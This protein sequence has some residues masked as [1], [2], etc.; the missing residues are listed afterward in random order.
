MTFSAGARYAAVICGLCAAALFLSG[1]ASLG[2]KGSRVVSADGAAS[3][4]KVA[5]IVTESQDTITNDVLPWLQYG[6]AGTA[7]TM[8]CVAVVLIVW[9]NRNSY[10]FQKPKYEA[11]KAEKIRNGNGGDA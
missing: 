11:A 2:V 5:A 1:C 6:F 7:V 8:V 9:I 10:I 4:N 3:N